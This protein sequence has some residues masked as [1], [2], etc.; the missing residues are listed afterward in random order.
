M[1]DSDFVLTVLDLE[2]ERIVRC[3]QHRREFESWRSQAPHLA[4]IECLAELVERIDSAPVEEST[5][6]VWALLDLVAESE[7]ATR[8]ML[9]VIVPGSVASWRG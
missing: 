4:E 2:W 1:A 6:M 3:R 7:L 5:E 8:A 9:Q